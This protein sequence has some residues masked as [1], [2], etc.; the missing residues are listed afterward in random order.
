MERLTP[1]VSKETHQNLDSPGIERQTLQGLS[2][3]YRRCLSTHPSMDCRCP[4]L[5][6]MMR[7][8]HCNPHYG[9]G[10]VTISGDDSGQLRNAP[11]ALVPMETDVSIIE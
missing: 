5:P 10:S 4:D 11:A 9:S 3:K 2:R 8:V 1:K 6:I 7:R